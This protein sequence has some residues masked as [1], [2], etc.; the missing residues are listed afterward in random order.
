MQITWVGRV[1]ACINKKIRLKSWDSCGIV[2]DD[3]MPVTYCTGLFHQNDEMHTVLHYSEL[4]FYWLS[5]L[6]E[7]QL[8]SDGNHHPETS[9]G[10][11]TVCLPTNI[12][13]EHLLQSVSQ[14]HLSKII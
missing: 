2:D 6:A 3:E 11:A 14:L 4:L 1:A 13:T 5:L 10:H 12:G 7:V 9:D 8:W